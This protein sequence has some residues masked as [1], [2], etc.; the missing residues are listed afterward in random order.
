MPTVAAGDLKGFVEIAA[1]ELRHHPARLFG[2]GLF[3]AWLQIVFTSPSLTPSFMLNVPFLSQH[4]VWTASLLV[5]LLT[6]AFVLAARK[7]FSSPMGAFPL[8]TCHLLMAAGTACLAWSA[9]ADESFL[10]SCIGIICTGAGSGFAFLAWGEHLA[11]LEPRRVLFD[12]AVYSFMTAL[13]FSAA[14]FLPPIG[15]QIA[16]TTMPILAG[17]LLMQANRSAPQHAT[18]NRQ[19]NIETSPNSVSLVGLAVLV[20]LVYGIMRGISLSFTT[21]SLE[22]VTAATVAGIAVAGIL[23]VATT[24][25]FRKGSE[26]YLVCQ[27]SFPLLAAGFLL[28]PQFL[29]DLPLPIIVFTVGHSYFYFLL[30][31]FCVDQVQASPKKPAVVFAIGLLSFLGS[32]LVGSI[33]SDAMALA[34]SEASQAISIISLIVVYLFVVV[35]AYLF[36]KNR[37]A[38]L[39]NTDEQR[40]LAFKNCSDLVAS[41][42]GL[43][44][45]ETEIFYLLAIGK[46]RADIR[47]TFHISNDTVKSHTRRIYAKLDI[48]S[49]KEAAALVE[50]RLEKEQRGMIAHSEGAQ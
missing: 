33:A 31:V 4:Q 47:D 17:I 8:A 46:D 34:G 45:R 11:R 32:S 26:L 3:W 37:K 38:S 40:A 42:G 6:F 48:H 9:M 23:L 28:L 25:F 10:F 18:A 50:D 43:S 22:H 19:P 14:M 12:M 41:D 29:G 44:P 1:D 7:S 49:K 27:I 24:V 20:G 15:T 2:M 39:A 16:T 5:T 13:F 35:F 21:S 30:W 36:G